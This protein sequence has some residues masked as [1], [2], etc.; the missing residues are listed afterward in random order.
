MAAGACVSGPSAN[1]Q[2][3]E[4]C[5][6]VPILLDGGEIKTPNVVKANRGRLVCWVSDPALGLEWVVEFPGPTPF[7]DSVN[8][9]YSDT[10]RN[11]G[12]IRQNASGFYRYKVR[13]QDPRDP[14]KQIEL[15]PW[16]DV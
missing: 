15:D 5:R 6:V 1:A 16:I 12:R 9:F 13:V 4:N 14:D 3:A 11:Q 8:Q 10:V 7:E 2:E